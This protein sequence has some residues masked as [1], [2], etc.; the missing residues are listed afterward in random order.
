MSSYWGSSGGSYRSYWWDY[1]SSEKKETKKEKT[2]EDDSRYDWRTA[3]KSRY[4]SSLGYSS[5]KLSESIGYGSSW[6]SSY[7]AEDADKARIL[8]E[9]TYKAARD[10]V[11]I[12]DLPF[13]VSIQMTSSGGEME[14]GNYRR[15]FLPTKVLDD[16]EYTEADKI[17]ICSGQA[18]HEAAHLKYTELSVIENFSEKMSY[19]TVEGVTTKSIKKI[20]FIKSLIN[21]IEDERVESL[22]LQERPGYIEFIDKAKTYQYKNFIRQ[23]KSESG[24][25]T[26]FLNNLYRLIRYP[27][28]IEDEV[29]KNYSTYYEKIKNILYPLPETTKDSCISAYRIYKVLLEIFKD[30]KIKGI[31]EDNELEIVLNS[32]TSGSSKILYGYDKDSLTNPSTDQ[33]YSELEKGGRDGTGG[34]LLA[35][36]VKGIAIKT[37]NDTYFRIAKGDEKKYRSLARKISP[38]INSIKKVLKTSNRNY[39]FN[40]H[41][42]RSGLLDEA[43]IAEAVQG[44]PQVYIR[45]GKVETTGSA[46]VVLI[47]ESGSM[48]SGCFDF[49]GKIGMARKAAILIQEAL[50]GTGTDLYI[51]GHTADTI[52]SGS[53]EIMIYQE[54]GNPTISPYALSS[55]QARYENRDGVAILEVA[56][57]VRKKTSKPILMFVLSD[58]LP[59]ARDYWGRGS[60]IDVHNK[61]KKVEGMDFTIVQV[62]IDTMNE[63]SCK[64]M[65]NNI[66]HLEKD[67][68]DLPKKLGKVIKKAILG[69]RKTEVS[70]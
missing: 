18:I 39:E 32:F 29:L 49:D 68:S 31:E 37:E 38:Y 19:S 24:K 63:E 60:E 66:V 64:R 36:L 54:T 48:D 16:S 52:Y 56:K 26:A 10:L 33:V 7:S 61:V 8:I 5:S 58:G 41:G 59:C 67:L 65:F 12:L 3:Y 70:L 11:V 45:K 34:K 20:N 69:N 46:V 1:W 62:T 17:S 55:V 23:R 4:R 6:Y 15:I 22:L 25:V 40:I 53:T 27:E 42:C 50:K 57:R 28:G 43:K 9:K 13:K 21:I 51:Y 14:F 30:L 35:E 44:V 2:I 47:D